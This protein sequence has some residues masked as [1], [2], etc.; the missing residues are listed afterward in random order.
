MNPSSPALISSIKSLLI[1]KMA[2]PNATLTSNSNPSVLLNANPAF[3]NANPNSRL[4][5][6]EEEKALLEQ[7]IQVALQTGGIDLDDANVSMEIFSLAVKAE[8][9]RKD[10]IVQKS[11]AK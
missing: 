4:V 11:T 6:Y 3:N 5:T 1:I 7:N 2:T 8:Q 10:A 9:E